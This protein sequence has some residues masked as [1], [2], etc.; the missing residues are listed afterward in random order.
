MRS[1]VFYAFFVI[2]LLVYTLTSAVTLIMPYTTRYRVLTSWADLNLWCLER[3]CGLNYQVDGLHNLPD[4]PSVVMSNHQSTWETLVL[5][6]FFPP[7]CWVVKRELMWI[8]FFGWSLAM[9]QPIAINRGAGRRAVDQLIQQGQARLNSGRWV[10]V[11]PQGTRVAPGKQRRFKLGGAVL[12]NKT[13]VPVIPVAHNSGYFWPR[14]QFLKY[15]GTITVSLGPPVATQDKSPE[16]IMD[17][18]KNW[19]DTELEVIGGPPWQG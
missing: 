13:Q 17:E 5:K 14:R 11:F 3:V 16:E 12:A 19:I 1:T 2:T 4:K 10:I 15:P 6:R 8:P 9:L 7:L 18:V